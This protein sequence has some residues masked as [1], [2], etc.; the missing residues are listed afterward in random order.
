MDRQNGKTER[1]RQNETG[2]MV[3]AERDRHKGTDTMGQAECDRLDRT[4]R[5]VMP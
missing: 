5:S 4:A 1:D 2:R 3:Q